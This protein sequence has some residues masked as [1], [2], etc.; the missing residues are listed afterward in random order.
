MGELA[1]EGLPGHAHR[2]VKKSLISDAVTAPELIDSGF[3]ERDDLA[4]FEEPWRLG[5][6]TDNHSASFLMDSGYLL[7]RC[8]VAAANAGSWL[9]MST[10]A[11]YARYVGRSM[12]AR[13]ARPCS[14]LASSAGKGTFVTGAT[15]P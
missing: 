13:S 8:L 11:R 4:Q 3:V 5:Q 2:R 6:H 7:K 9:R 12:P 14:S 1:A 10:L 15:M